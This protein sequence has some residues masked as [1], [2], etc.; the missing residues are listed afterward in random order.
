MSVAPG[1]LDIVAGP[2]RRDVEHA[3]TTWIVTRMLDPVGL[4]VVT[5]G[6]PLVYADH[7][8]DVVRALPPYLTRL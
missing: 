2:C 6:V 1:D 4:T 3:D 5:R 8:G 7:D